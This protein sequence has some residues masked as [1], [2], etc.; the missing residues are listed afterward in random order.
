MSDVIDF[1]PPG[2][3]LGIAEFVKEALCDGATIS[4]RLKAAGIAPTKRKGRRDL[5]RL[6]DLMHAAF[7]TNNDGSF[8]ASGLD[9]FRARAFFQAES[10]KLKLQERA[11]ELIPRLEVEQ[12]LGRVA[13]IVTEC[14]ET[15]PDKLERDAGATPKQIVIWEKIINELRERVYAGLVGDD[16][17]IAL[18]P[19]DQ[20]AE[21][22]S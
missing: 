6:S 13:K 21:G 2:I 14:L 3:H 15:L 8:N 5:Y 17:T 18:P 7:L 9:P 19:D 4:R 16:S 1:A 22:Q 12:E 11:R 10:E 20:T